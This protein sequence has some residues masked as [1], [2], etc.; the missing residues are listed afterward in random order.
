M[1]LWPPLTGTQLSPVAPRSWVLPSGHT[2]GN[3]HD[4]RAKP[5]EGLRCCVC[6]HT[7]DHIPILIACYPNHRNHQRLRLHYNHQH[8]HQRWDSL[9]NCPQCDRTFTLRIGL[10]GHFRIHCAE[11]GEPVPGAPSHSRDRRLHCPH[12]RRAFAHH[13][14]LFGH[15][16]IHAS[17][18]HRNADN[19][20]TPSTPSAPAILTPTATATTMNDIPPSSYDFSGPQYARNFNSRIGLI[21]HLLRKVDLERRVFNPEWTDE[22]FFVQRS[23]KALCLLCDDTN[24]TFKRSNLKG[25]FDAKQAHTYR[26]YTTEERKTEAVR[27]Q[28]RLDQQSSLFKKQ[29]SKA[30]EAAEHRI[31]E[32]YEVSLFGF[33]TDISS[34]L[35]ELNLE[36]QG[37]DVLI[38]NM[39]AHVRAF[40]AKLI[41]W[42][43]Q[44]YKGN[45]VHFP[46]LAQYDA[47]LSDTKECISVLST[48]RNEFSSRFTDVRSHS[49]EFKIVSARFDFPYDDAPSDVQLELIEL[50]ALDVLLS[51][52]TSCTTL[53][54]FYRQLPH[55]QFPML[56]T[57]GKR[58]I[59]M[60]GSTYSC[61]RLFSKM[62][63]CKNK[64][65]SQLTDNRLNDILLL[66]SSS[67]EPDILSV[68][69]SMQNH[70]FH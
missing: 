35:N 25:H 42:E 8:Y 58:V 45:Y 13:M 47:A 60:F 20:D 63:F 62:K 64:L 30:S 34:H 7:R 38:A 41:L 5:G 31:R 21:G 9:L 37:R 23:N 29:A 17:G 61:E 48:L 50:Q 19:T 15:M 67:L 28:S 14:G 24:S 55:A 68:S 36:L 4:R 69:K 39:E 33:L 53:I 2:P 27:L 40:E 65:R 57:R 59:A 16:Q 52:F 26:D 11:T 22:L 66:N 44:L 51:K 12:C 43:K 54:D 32:S 3:R 56:L 46:H 70:V 1:L 10:V 49:Q 18:I 6:L